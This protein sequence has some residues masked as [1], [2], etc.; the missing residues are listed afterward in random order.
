MSDTE[1]NPD[2]S[3]GNVDMALRWIKSNWT[4][5]AFLGGLAVYQVRNDNDT[6]HD[7]KNLNQDI[8]EIKQTA[9]GRS[10]IADSFY[11]KVDDLTPRVSNIEKSQEQ[12]ARMFERS[13]ERADANSEAVR[14]DLQSIS[15]QVSV[16]SSKVDDLRSS[17]PRKTSF[18]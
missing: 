10:Q 2:H 8:A 1:V 16:V 13:V 12:L 11:K 15:V 6:K 5:L 9:A 17:A 18:P 7:L 3:T 14:K 4:I